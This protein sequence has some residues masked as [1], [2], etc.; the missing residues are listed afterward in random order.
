M[1]LP[2]GAEVKI[3][4]DD[5][6]M[7]FSSEDNFV[8]VG[9]QESDGEKFPNLDVFFTDEVVASATISL[10][11]ITDKLSLSDALTRS[12]DRLKKRMMLSMEKDHLAFKSVG[13][14]TSVED[15]INCDDVEILKDENLKVIIPF[16]RIIEGIKIYDEMEVKFSLITPPSG[17]QSVNLFVMFETDNWRYLILTLA[18][19]EDESN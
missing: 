6:L 12:E 1:S 15:V 17:I 16:H 13:S 2:Y 10:K 9:A 4:C 11:E 19:D 8:Y 3:R 14:K 5:K 18:K 7:E